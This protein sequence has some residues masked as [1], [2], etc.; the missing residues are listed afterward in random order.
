MSGQ[1]IQ[2][3]S[4]I[5]GPDVLAVGQAVTTPTHSAGQTFSTWLMNKV[6]KANHDLVQ[7]DSMAKAFALDDSIPVHQVTYAMEQA[8]ISL[9]I[10]LQVRTH[11][12]DAYQELTRMQL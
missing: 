12:V 9:E 7:A 10:M 4:A 11:L 8:K 2:P 5:L 1:V 3:I 6:D